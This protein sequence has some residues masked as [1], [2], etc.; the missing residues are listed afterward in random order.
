MHHEDSH[1][2]S[3]TIYINARADKAVFQHTTTIYTIKDLQVS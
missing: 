1:L 2:S 3:L